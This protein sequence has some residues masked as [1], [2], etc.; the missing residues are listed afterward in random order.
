M[1]LYKLP[2][3]TNL[4]VLIIFYFCLSCQS[5]QSARQ[6]NEDKFVQIYCDVVVLSDLIKPESRQILADS[7]FAFYE[8]S[9]QDF[10][11]T[12]EIYSKDNRKW[13]KI[14]EKIVAELEARSPQTESSENKQKII[15]PE[16][17]LS[18]RNK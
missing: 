11:Y 2:L 18:G 8:V 1:K 12:V 5:Q 4:L 13:K 6:I 16:K 14:Y 10:Y 17:K 3:L 9:R 7:V 15:E